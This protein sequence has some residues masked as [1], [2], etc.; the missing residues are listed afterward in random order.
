MFM[1]GT[2]VFWHFAADM[3]KTE[4]L[5]YRQACARMNLPE[6]SYPRL[7]TTRLWA[8]SRNPNYFGELLIYS[9][10]CL[11]SMH[12]VPAVWLLSMVGLYVHLF[13]LENKKYQY[14]IDGGMDRYWLPSMRLKDKSL[15]RFGDEW[16]QYKRSTA[17]FIPYI[18]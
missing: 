18:W 5:A 8:F 6:G 11:L 7:L 14:F 3:Q 16:E 4:F 15:S 12:W 10:F 9:S 1:F 2:G 17:F 13:D